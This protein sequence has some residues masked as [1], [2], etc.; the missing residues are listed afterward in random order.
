MLAGSNFMSQPSAL[1]PVIPNSLVVE[2]RTPV[3]VIP[4]GG[5][6]DL[7]CNATWN[8]TLGTQ[9]SVTWSARK[10][11]A[12]LED[13]LTFGPD[14]AVAVTDIAAQRYTSGGL[15]LDLHRKGTYGLVLSG[16]V[17][18]DQGVYVCTVREWTREAGGDWFRLQQKRTD[19]GHVSITPTGM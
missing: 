15:R 5:T 18:A 12:T 19:I 11:V 14:G 13:L 7:F 17:P 1:L 16:A 8:H 2:P 3:A 6:V 10:G 4:E 9:L